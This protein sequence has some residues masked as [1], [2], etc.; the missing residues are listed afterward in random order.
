MEKQ[1]LKRGFGSARGFGAW[2]CFLP[3][4]N[5]WITYSLRFYVTGSFGLVICRHGFDCS[6]SLGKRR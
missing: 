5:S 2:G 4:G 1:N 6:T 3:T